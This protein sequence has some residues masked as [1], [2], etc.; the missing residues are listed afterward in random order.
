MWLGAIGGAVITMVMGF[1]IYMKAVVPH[2]IMASLD[3]ALIGLLLFIMFVF[4]HPFR[5]RLALGPQDFVV[6][7]HILDDVDKGY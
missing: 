6:A 2:L 4:S 1:M 3:G 5:G 7:L